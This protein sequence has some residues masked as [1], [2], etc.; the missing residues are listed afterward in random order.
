MISMGIPCGA[1]L[2]KVSKT[3]L[4]KL[5]LGMSDLVF[6]VHGYKFEDLPRLMGQVSKIAGRYGKTK[7]SMVIGET[8]QMDGKFNLILT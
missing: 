6:K 7:V 3:V 5:I 4:L 8:Y 1:V 2:V